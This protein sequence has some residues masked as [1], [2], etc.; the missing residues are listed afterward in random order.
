MASSA[1]GW[2]GR[3]GLA[4]LFL[5]SAVVLAQEQKFKVLHTFHG[6]DGA[7]PVGQLVRDRAGNFYSTTANGGAGKCKGGCGTAF[8]I[9]KTG[10]EVWLH[11]FSGKNGRGPSAGLLRDSAGNLYGT[12]TFGGAH[13]YGM[14][15]PGC[16]VV[17]GLN[18]TGEETLLYSFTGAP[19]GWFPEALLVGDGAGNLY[20]TT[21]NGGTFDNG[22]TVF[23]VD[24]N[25]KET[26]LYSFCSLSN[27]AD[28]DSPY[29]GV[30]RD[31]TG[32][33]YGVT[34]GGDFGAGVVF[35]LDT[36]GGETVLYSFTGGPDGGGPNS[37]LLADSKGNL[38]GMTEG[39]GNLNCAGGSGCG[40]IFELSPQSDGSWREATLYTFCSLSNC[41]DGRYPYGGPLVLDAAG[42]IYGSTILGGA[43]YR[44]C[45]GDGCGVVFKLDTTGKETVLH[46]FDGGAGGTYPWLG[47]M[48]ASG[49]LYGAT[50]QGGDLN[51]APNKG[52][53]C[54]TLFKITQ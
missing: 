37:V 15:F 29:V 48:D 9:D 31:T 54:G 6:P 13:C 51:C 42:N 33:L 5:A 53:G 14:G 11:S 18:K 25:G 8:K 46:S 23:K 36:T 12:T 21:I 3:T 40:V 52:H 44:N 34:R 38:Y 47:V 16:G 20:G 27:C 10:K 19:N 39:G 7:N 4:L 43:Y 24:K 2:I 45:A 17:F 35:R 49:N 28:G 30:I 32:N 26:V 41:T 1:P 22:G 50:G